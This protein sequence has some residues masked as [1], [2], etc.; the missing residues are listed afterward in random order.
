MQ[1]NSEAVVTSS[2]RISHTK[3]G[4][5]VDLFD[6]VKN[7][8]E[9]TPEEKL[10]QKEDKKQRKS[11]IKD[12]LDAIEIE[13]LFCQDR[14]KERISMI[15]TASIIRKFAGKLKLARKLLYKRAM[16]SDKI[17]EMCIENKCVPT[18]K[19]IGEM[20]NKKETDISR[21]L[22]KFMAKV[23]STIRK[24]YDRK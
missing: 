10:I 7:E 18:N 8:K 1:A 6:I 24:T 14:E 2:T 5:E 4:D 15:I 13:F 12:I 23:Q 11:E 16:C 20:F 21:T 17:F 3:D 19:E 22:K 9:L